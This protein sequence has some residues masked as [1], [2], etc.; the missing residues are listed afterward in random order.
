[1]SQSVWSAENMDWIMEDKTRQQE[2]NRA[3]RGQRDS[4]VSAPSIIF[5]KSDNK[6]LRLNYSHSQFTDGEI[7]AQRSEVTCLHCTTGKRQS[8][9]PRFYSKAFVSHF[10]KWGWEYA[11]LEGWGSHQRLSCRRLTL[12]EPDQERAQ[13]PAGLAAHACQGFSRKNWLLFWMNQPSC[14][15]KPSPTLL[16]SADQKAFSCP[17]RLPAGWEG[18]YFAHWTTVYYHNT[19]QWAFQCCAAISCSMLQWKHTGLKGRCWKD[20]SLELMRQGPSGSHWGRTFM[21]R[22]LQQILGLGKL[23]VWWARCKL[24]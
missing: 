23:L 14:F 2:D 22:P 11:R 19:E 9:E 17:R 16:G 3:A 10:L 21:L 8:W 1:M 20:S 6:F 4:W 7:E 18:Q 5:F 15:W 24:F 13:G 12:L